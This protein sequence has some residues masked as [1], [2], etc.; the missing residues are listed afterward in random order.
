MYHNTQVRRRMKMDIFTYQLLVAFA[1]TCLRECHVAAADVTEGRQIDYGVII[2]A[3]SS[4]SRVRVYKWPRKTSRYDV[5]KVL[6][7][8]HSASAWG[9]IVAR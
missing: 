4:G 9:S 6:L 3:G 2:D 8:Y 1:L 7:S 5:T